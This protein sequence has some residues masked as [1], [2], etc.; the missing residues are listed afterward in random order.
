MARFLPLRVLGMSLHHSLTEGNESNALRSNAEKW[1]ETLWAD[2]SMEHGAFWS[3]YGGSKQ[4]D[5]L[6]EG[7]DQS[8]D[9]CWFLQGKQ[10]KSKREKGELG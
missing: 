3:A 5:T 7:S 1:K 2:E 9:V 4:V 10:P 8:S 6:K